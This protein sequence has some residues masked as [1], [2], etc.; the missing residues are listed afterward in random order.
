MVSEELD[1]RARVV[2]LLPSAALLIALG[3]V[4]F[5]IGG[6]TAFITFLAMT[7]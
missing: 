7:R 4:V 1:D 5:F 6:Y 3:C 2:A